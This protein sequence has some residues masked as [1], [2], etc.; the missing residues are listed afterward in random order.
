MLC[1]TSVGEDVL[2][3][4]ELGFPFTWRFAGDLKEQIL[5]KAEFLKRGHGRAACLFKDVVL[6]VRFWMQCFPLPG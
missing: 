4:V 6:T 5:Q 1:F 3:A 2:A